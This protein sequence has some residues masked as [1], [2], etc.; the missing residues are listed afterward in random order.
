V[1]K[2]AKTQTGYSVEIKNIGGYASPVDVA[3]TYADGSNEIFHQTPAIWRKNQKQTTVSITTK[4]K[5][6]KLELN[7]GIWMDADESNNVWKQ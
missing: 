7:G 4:K 6:Q 3:V 5:I 2:V 1:E